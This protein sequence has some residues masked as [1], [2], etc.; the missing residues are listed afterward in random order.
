MVLPYKG[1]L[2]WVVKSG[3]PFPCCQQGATLSFHRTP[4]FLARDP[5]LQLQV[6]NDVSIF[7]LASHPS[8][9][10]LGH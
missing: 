3:P 4:T 2:L 9:A 10:S 1:I 7:S 8:D 5:P 6:C